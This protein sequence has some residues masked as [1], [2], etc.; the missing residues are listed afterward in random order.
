MA[1]QPLVSQASLHA[2]S[3]MVSNSGMRRLI[4]DHDFKQYG[5][6]MKKLLKKNGIELREKCTFRDMIQYS[7][8]HLL[9][10]Y[11]HE[12]LY[13]TALLNSYVL[14]HYSLADTILLNEF[15]IGNSKADAV[16]VN[17]TNKVFEIKTELDNPD[18]LNSQLNDY[19]KAFSE[20]Y[21]VVYHEHSERYR[22]LLDPKVGIMTFQNNQICV[23]RES[24]VDHTKLDSATM[25]KA[26]RKEEYLQVVKNL[27]NSI[28]EVPPVSLFKACLNVVFNYGADEVQ[29]EFLK[30]IKKRI[31]QQLNEMVVTVDLPDI[32]KLSCYYSNINQNEYISLIKRLNF[33]F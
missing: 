15:K 29:L 12:Y 23:V 16:L 6:E 5:R 1:N 30:V 18:R 26:L 27:S 10:C 24:T 2:L 25:M 11:R 7:Y 33:S 20:V 28:P 3:K 21:V 9:S 4:F 31:N 13:K 19:Y 22:L 14:Q 17:G 32:L 8:D